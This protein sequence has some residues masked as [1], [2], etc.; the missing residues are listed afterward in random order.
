[1]GK[2]TRIPFEQI[3]LKGDRQVVH[4]RFIDVSILSS[5]SPLKAVTCH[6]LTTAIGDLARSTE[7]YFM[8]GNEQSVF[9]FTNFPSFPSFY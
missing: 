3:S 5:L 7:V 9:I 1:M 6:S 2:N 8:G 4:G